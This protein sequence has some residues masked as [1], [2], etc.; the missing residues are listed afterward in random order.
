MFSFKNK[1]V[2]ACI[3][4][5]LDGELI[6]VRKLQSSPIELEKLRSGFLHQQSR[7]LKDHWYL[8]TGL[9]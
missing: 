9:A 8:H 7:P 3:L 5:F 2:S 6:L 4:S 1:F